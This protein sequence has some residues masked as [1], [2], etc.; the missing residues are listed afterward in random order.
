M[1]ITSDRYAKSLYEANKNLL[2]KQI[3]CSGLFIEEGVKILRLPVRFNIELLNSKWL[4]GLENA[5]TSFEPDVIIAHGIINITSIRI[6]LLK[7]KLKNSKLI[8]DDHM[9][10]NATRGGWINLLYKL[11]RATFTPIFL[12]S[13]DAFVAV[14]NETREFMHK[15]YGIPLEKVKIIPL[16]IDTDHFRFD[17]Q[18]RDIIR[19]KFGIMDDE[20][21]FIYAGKIILKKGVHLFVNA[22]LQLCTH[23]DNVKFIIVGG[24]DPSYLAILKKRIKR[25]KMARYFFFMGAVPNQELYKY[26]SAAEVGVWPLQCSV[27][28]L[29]A[30]AC[31]LPIVISD[32]SGATERVASGNGLLYS[33][34]DPVDLANKLVL[35]LDPDLRHEM[36]KKAI[37]YA[38][39]LCWNNL[40][41]VF[42]NS[43]NRKT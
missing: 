42:L 26:Y 29:E 13:A 2:K 28:M 34:S 38:N 17:S 41:A 37:A 20:V 22:A 5:V 14:T 31:G 1:V 16:G 39:T 15:V 7:S 24:N 3:V 43:V 4:I 33:E 36:S 40:A 11:F 21:V 30:T 23:H 18:A 8:F 32:K 35:L 6:A 9:T 27:T 10:Y 25:M 19:K 12:K